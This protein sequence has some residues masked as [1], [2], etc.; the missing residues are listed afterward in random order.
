MKTILELTEYEPT[1]LAESAITHSMGEAIW[2]NYG[3]KI[4]I[5][6][7]T[8]KTENQWQLTS[9]GW[10]GYIPFNSE[11]GISLKPKAAL[12]NIFGMLEYAYHLKSF[13]FLEGFFDCE[14][15][16]EF[17]ERL[18]NILARQVLDRGRRGFYRAYIPESDNLPYLRG[19]MDISHA[20]R[21]P[22]NNKLL[23][24]YEEHTGD[25]EENQILAWTLSKI[26]KSGMCTE[27]V[28]PAVRRA[29]RAL[30]GF[31]SLRAY[32][33][34]ECIGRSYNRLNEDYHKMHA[35]CRFFLEHSGPSHK[36]G[37][38]T[39]LPFLLNM[40][41]LYELFVAEWL[42]AHLPA[43]F[44]LR[45]QERV[46]IDQK[47]NLHFDIDLVIYSTITGTSC[48]VL[49]TKYKVASTPLSSDIAQVIAYAQTKDCVGAVLIYPVRLENPIDAWSK[50]IHI[51]SL[52]L[53]LDG[54]LA[55]C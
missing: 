53:S 32:Q 55:G 17:Y 34:K 33:P 7:P 50:N 11:F 26:A 20:I 54:D 27:R 52:V 14:S 4:A 1:R 16:E 10:V 23:C 40:E 12:C 51:R 18:A 41:R 24:H 29:Y 21:R 35:L 37:D 25:I 39:M 15:L 6:F 28:L 47:Q 5:E 19:R 22:W 38:R 13:Q 36:L 42:K 2:R 44:A 30:Q 8:P 49:D 3:A 43:E 45:M 9:Q 31:V 46:E 48:Y